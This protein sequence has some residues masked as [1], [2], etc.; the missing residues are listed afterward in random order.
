MHQKFQCCYKTF[1][2]AIA[3]KN[4]HFQ[5]HSFRNTNSDTINI[6]ESSL[7]SVRGPG[8]FPK[9]PMAEL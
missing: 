2:D 1:G 3:L 8:D 7:K 9:T 4:V 5:E 6:V